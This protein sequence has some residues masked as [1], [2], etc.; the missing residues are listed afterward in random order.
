MHPIS[1][2]HGAAE[3]YYTTPPLP[4]SH[5]IATHSP[6]QLPCAQMSIPSTQS[7][8][9]S[10]P[11]SPATKSLIRT[12][13]FLPRHIP[14]WIQ[15]TIVWRSPDL[16][17]VDDASGIALVSLNL[18]PK[19]DPA[20]NTD[21]LFAG[22]YVMVIGRVIKRLIRGRVGMVATTVRD[23]TV[24]APMLECLWNLEVVDAFLWEKERE[25]AV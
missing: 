21:A 16:I 20:A 9:S 22:M 12:A 13:R 2:Y 4:P 25:E 18:L 5:S 1:A 19:E 14:A 7:P 11:I 23:L 15:G 17:A 24:Y 3:L 10:T 6:P 8:N